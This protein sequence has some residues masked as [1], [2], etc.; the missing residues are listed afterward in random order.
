MENRNPGKKRFKYVSFS[1]HTSRRKRTTSSITVQAH[2]CTVPK[3]R[4]VKTM[5]KMRPHSIII[6]NTEY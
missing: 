5:R 3:A 4:G 2:T 6:L 1:N